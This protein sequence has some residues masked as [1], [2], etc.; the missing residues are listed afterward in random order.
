[1]PLKP[2]LKLLTETGAGSRRVVADAIRQ[3]RVLVNGIVAENFHQEIDMERDR[4]TLDGRLLKLKPEE[5]IYLMMNKPEGILS[6]TEDDRGR[7]TVRDILPQ[8]YNSFRLYPAGRL[9][10]D[11]TG[12]LLLTNDGELTQHVTHPSFQHEKEYLLAI[13]GKLSLAEMEVLRKG[14]QLEDGMTHPA[15]VSE[16]ASAPPYNYSLTI[17]EGRKR[18]VRRMLG[19]L[20]HPVLKLKRIRIASLKLGGLNEGKVR[21]LSQ[22]EVKELL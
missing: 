22:E 4:V 2:L 3:G 17:H 16:I 18:Q 9:D 5:K 19:S 1:M 21:P 7:R 13:N 12:L 14:V 8:A 20:G 11:S 6:T 10:K 15:K